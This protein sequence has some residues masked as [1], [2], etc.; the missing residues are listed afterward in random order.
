[1]TAAAV[2]ELNQ[3]TPDVHLPPVPFRMRGY[4][5]PTTSAGMTE[6]SERLA[7]A[8]AAIQGPYQRRPGDVRTLLWRARALDIPV[9]VAIDHIYITMQGKAGLSAQLIAALIRR[10]G[11]EWTTVKTPHLVQF[12]FHKET[13]YLTTTG[14]IR[15]RT[16]QLGVVKF[17]LIE[18][19]TAGIAGTRHWQAWP[20][21]CMWARAMARAGRELFSDITMGF[22]Y[23]PEELHD[24]TATEAAPA[25]DSQV[26]EPVLELINQAL[27]EDATAAL[28]KTDIMVRARTA[29]L[30]K[31]HAGD[32]QT[33][34]QVLADIWRQKTAFEEDQELAVAADQAMTAAGITTPNQPAASTDES[35][36]TA[37]LGEGR[38]PC[39]CPN[40]AV[41]TDVHEE[42]CAGVMP[43]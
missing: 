20:I 3:L 1:M 24:G 32:G 28:I 21:P 18:A 38:L 43:E 2:L 12:T 6:E 35:W 23:T 39:G 4:D 8:R 31:E 41:I 16:K 9:G 36:K 13:W 5:G 14:K 34:A 25:A 30:L 26:T 42:G 29:R 11:V 7:E 33:L 27:S 37:Q 40:T 19:Q 10:A 22:A 17:E 15:K